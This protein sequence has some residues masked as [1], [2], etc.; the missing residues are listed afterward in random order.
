MVG[1]HENLVLTSKTG[2][3]EKGSLVIGFQFN[4]SESDDILDAWDKGQNI[5]DKEINLIQFPFKSTDWQGKALTY[6]QVIESIEELK[7][8]LVDILT[9]FM[10]VAK[11]QETLAVNS[12][13]LRGLGVNK[14]NIKTAL[15]ND[16]VL[17]GAYKNM[18]TAFSQAVA[19]F[20]GKV[21]VRVMLQRTS[22]KNHFATIPPQRI[23]QVWIESM[24]VPKATSLVQWS[25]YQLEKNLND[26]TPVPA[27]KED[28]SQADAAFAAP[29]PTFGSPAPAFS[30]PENTGIPAFQTA[31]AAT[32]GVDPFNLPK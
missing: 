18:C 24:A 15:T 30:V 16:T 27:D 6:T 32:P 25:K 9:V 28:T 11:A 14:E 12:V 26:G 1:I 29:T 17:Q 10:P 2:L 19:P 3:N 23:K 20:V 31:S 4:N 21:P 8:K 7:N 13:I 22:A 5:S